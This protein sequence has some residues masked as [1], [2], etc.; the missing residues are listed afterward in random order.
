MI[1]SRHASSL[2]VRTLA[3]LLGGAL[4]L[5]APAVVSAAEGG[6]GGGLIDLNWTLFVQIANF[7]VLLVLLYV[8]AYK[9]LVAML[10]TRADAIRQQLAEAQAARE[11]AQR[12]LAEFD[13]RL[14]AA[15]A[16]A[17]A[18]RERATREAAETRERLTAEAR[19]EAARLVESARAQIEQ[20]VRRA[21]D[22]LRAEVGTLALAIAERL[23]QRSL[24]DEDHQRLVQEAIGRMDA[25]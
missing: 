12:Q 1:R 11:Q 8:F 2:P 18:L 25:R 10:Q 16:E 4:P 19:R 14:Q 20:D 5:F 3:L 21:R 15:H 7:L 6:E 17:Q 24:R 22:E 9:P 23:I 13:S